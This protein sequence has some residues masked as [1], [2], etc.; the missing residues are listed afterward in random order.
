MGGPIS[1][2]ELVLFTD[3]VGS[4]G[5]GAYFQGQWSAEGWPEDWRLAGFLKNLVLLDLFPIVL[6]VEI[7]G[8]AFCIKKVRFH[9]DN[10]GVVSAINSTSACS[11]P[12]VRLL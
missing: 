12:V 7:W 1:N 9:C 10:M 11:P 5:Y 8:E 6:V 4:A 3:A 2:A